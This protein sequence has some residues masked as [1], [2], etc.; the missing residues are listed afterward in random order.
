MIQRW[1]SSTKAAVLWW[2]GVSGSVVWQVPA[3][4]AGPGGQLEPETRLA[5][6]PH[7]H[8]SAT[9]PSHHLGHR[10]HPM[11]AP[12]QT[13]PGENTPGKSS[14]QDMTGLVLRGVQEDSRPVLLSLLSSLVG[15]TLLLLLQPAHHAQL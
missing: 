6:P 14:L 15:A 11:V 4:R 9:A 13:P 5:P 10:S 1:W 12:A 2:C 8:L 7:L 3:G